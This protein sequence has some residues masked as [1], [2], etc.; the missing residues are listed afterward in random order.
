MT[1]ISD[2][3]AEVVSELCIAAERLAPKSTHILRNRL[4]DKF[5]L[6]L[7]HFSIYVEGRV[8]SIHDKDA[9]LW[10]DQFTA[11]SELILLF[12][13]SN[14]PDGWRFPDGETLVKVLAEC[15]GFV[16]IVTN[17]NTEF[18]LAFDDHDCLIGAGTSANW[19]RSLV[20]QSENESELTSY[21]VWLRT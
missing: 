7:N 16:F 2:E 9:W 5:G 8:E 18:L 17:S 10:I 15:S 20:L 14:E 4:H 11:D 3:I 6:D 21:C 1:H 12:P 13:K 19:I